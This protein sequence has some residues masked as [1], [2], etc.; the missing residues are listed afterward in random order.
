M[1]TRS[2]MVVKSLYL[3][4]VAALLIPLAA[5]STPST[6]DATGR[7]SQGGVLPQ[8]RDTHGLSQTSLGH[9]D[10][11]GEAIKLATLGMR[12]VA[13]NILWTKA[14]EYKK[15][16]DWTALSATL[17]QITHLQPHFIAVWRFQGWNLSYN[18]SVEWDDYRDRYTWVIKGVDFLKQGV[19]YNEHEPML[20]W[21]IGWILSHKIGRAD[22]HKQFRQLFLEDDDFHGSRPLAERDNWLVGKEWVRRAEELVDVRGQPVKGMQPLVFH[23]Y[24][25]LCQI[26]YA[27]ALEED[28]TFGEVARRAWSQAGR[29]WLE[30][31]QRALRQGPDDTPLR[32]DDLERQLARA[33]ALTEELFK[34]VPSGLLDQ[35]TAERME[36]LSPAERA[37]LEKPYDQRN[38][39]ENRLVG[40]ASEKLT[41]SLPDVAA[42]IE[43]DDGSK[44]R[45]LAR[46]AEVAQDIAS[47]IDR[48]SNIVNYRYWK[49]RCAAEQTDDALEARRL[50]Y[51]A[52]QALRESEFEKARELY[53]RGMQ[54]WRKT[55]D[56]FP[57]LVD[58]GIVGD[59]FLRATRRYRHVLKQ[60]EEPFPDEFVLQDVLDRHE[61][62]IPDGSE[63]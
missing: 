44:A 24:P 17:E 56:A 36:S 57:M 1:K 42:R 58:D 45:E 22:E 7:R 26:N 55:L 13:A 27:S 2:P 60:L 8:M 59:D 35:I 10:P 31:G 11:A 38:P 15:T 5:L 25:P 30:Y 6:P 3:A 39:E 46:E 9:I 47:F 54:S 28:G 51:Q 50:V 20:L 61:M 19:Q 29:E 37:A 52:D 48:G 40:E 21:D 53:E 43:G 41:I 18:V 16:E 32:L 33:N 12:G 4:G 63:Q 34:L 49:V 14:H 23:S 62:V